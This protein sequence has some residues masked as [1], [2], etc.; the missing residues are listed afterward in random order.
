MTTI[1][2]TVT[3]ITIMTTTDAKH[4]NDNQPTT[5]T[6]HEPTNGHKTT[7]NQQRTI[8]VTMTMTND[9]DNNQQQPTL[10]NGP[11]VNNNNKTTGNNNNNKTQ[12][13]QVINKQECVK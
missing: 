12:K 3:A 6:N 13:Q 8:T 10:N 11:T 1:M 2:T 9:S 5:L 7:I 4:A